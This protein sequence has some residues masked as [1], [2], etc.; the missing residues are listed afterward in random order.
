MPREGTSARDAE[1]DGWVLTLGYD[2]SDHHSFVAILRA[3]TWDEIAR[4]HLPFHVPMGLH[5]SF[6]S[7]PS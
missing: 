6:A 3:D 4:V 5:A 7:S 2:G 1:D